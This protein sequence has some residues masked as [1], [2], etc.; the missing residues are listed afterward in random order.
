MTAVAWLSI[1]AATACKEGAWTPMGSAEFVLSEIRVGGSPQVSKRIDSDENFGRSV[2]NGIATGD[3][4][5]LE[6]A[7]RL[8]PASAA[9]Q[10]TLSI[11]LATALPRSPDKVLALLG[12]KYPVEEVCGIPFLKADSALVM[13]YHDGAISALGRV[14]RASLISRRNAC[15]AA[16]DQARDRRLER[17]NPSYVVKNKPPTPPRRR[18]RKRAPAPA[19]R[20]TPKDTA[21]SD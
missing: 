9:A 15:R 10:A 13:A 2:M 17:V 21:S 18:P 12:Q 20:V 14:N 8:T 1:A 5:W 7:D 4:L 11:A 6:V 3:S 19:Q 16:L